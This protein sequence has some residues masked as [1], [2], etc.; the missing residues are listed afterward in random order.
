MDR[1]LAIRIAT[2]LIT[3]GA[4]W[5]V[6]T[7]MK[8]AYQASTGNKPPAADDLEVSLARVIV[9]AGTTAAVVAVVKTVLQR[10]VAAASARAQPLAPTH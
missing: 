6:E 1:Q 8:K 10:Q 2:P 3:V 5:A 9:Y 4:I 7:G